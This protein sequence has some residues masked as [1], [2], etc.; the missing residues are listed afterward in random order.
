MSIHLHP[1]LNFHPMMD[2]EALREQ[3][4]AINNSFFEKKLDKNNA[5]ESD[6]E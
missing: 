4:C 3:T 2:K 6:L 1:L 5:R